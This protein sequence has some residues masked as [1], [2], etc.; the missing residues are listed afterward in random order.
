MT[1]D[2]LSECHKRYV[3][4]IFKMYIFILYLYFQ[5]VFKH[6]TSSFVSLTEE[7]FSEHQNS[8]AQNILLS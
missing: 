6:I 5:G 1:A 2:E 4:R 7:R 3:M 8:V